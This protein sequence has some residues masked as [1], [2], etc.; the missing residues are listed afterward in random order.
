MSIN[1]ATLHGN[2]GQDPELKTSQGGKSFCNFSIATS[3]GWGENKKTNWHRC[4]AFGKLAEIIAE[5][6]KKGDEIVVSGSI[7]YNEHEGKKY[8]SI[9][10]NDFSLCRNAT[11]HGGGNQ[12]QGS[13][14][15]ASKTTSKD[16]DPSQH[17]DLPFGN[18]DDL[19][20]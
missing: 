13:A 19:E 20:F 1:T 8:T 12:D 9:L 15:S 6:V 18:E 11:S 16:L 3:D 4:T 14:P 10:V 2:L 7:D 5:Y 17:N